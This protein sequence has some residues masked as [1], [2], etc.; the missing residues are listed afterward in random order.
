MSPCIEPGIPLRL[1]FETSWR[2][3]LSNIVTADIYHQSFKVQASEGRDNLIE[4]DAEDRG[5]EAEAAD[6]A[7]AEKLLA[8]MPLTYDVRPQN[9]AISCPSQQTE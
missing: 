2:N 4:T 1:G 7:K 3:I 8:G 5:E 6:D 9:V